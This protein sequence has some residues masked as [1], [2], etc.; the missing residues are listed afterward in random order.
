MSKR[1]REAT[2]RML[3]AMDDGLLDPREVAHMALNWLSEADVDE[4]VRRNDLAE[5]IGLETDEEE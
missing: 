4:M 2:C 1:T 5:F 3:E